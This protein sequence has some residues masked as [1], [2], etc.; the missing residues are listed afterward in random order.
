MK[1]FAR[2]VNLA[3][4]LLLLA[5]TAPGQTVTGTLDGHIT[6]QAGAVVPQVKITAKNVQ[7]G[8]ER[9]TATNETGYFQLPFLPLGNYELTA[10]AA[11]FATVV[12][13]NIQV[14]LNKTTTIS[15]ALKISTV[16]ESVTVR[17]V[18]PL[19]DMTSGQIRRS[20]DDVM[21]GTLPIA[22]RNFLGF[23]GLFPG[24][25]TNPTSGQNN[26][27]L[28]SGSSV[29]FNGTGTRGT[30]F[31]TDG[32]SND[33][34]SENQNRQAVNISTIKEMQLLTDNFAPEFG[35][36][37]GAVVL[38]QTKSGDNTMH[39]EAYW[40]LQ[41]SALN[42]RGY[43]AN[44]A[45][46]RFD[47]AK[48]Q[49]VPNVAKGT[50][51]SHRAGGTLGGAI[52][53]DRLFYFGSMERFWEPGTL[54]ST[55]YL[56][57]PEWRT[58]R[59]DPSVPDA[60]ARRAWVQSLI[61][62]FPANLAPNNAPVSPYAYTA[63]MPRS[64]HTKDYSGRADW[65]LNDNNLVYARYQFSNFFFGRTQEIVKGENIKQDHRFQSVGVTHTHVFSPTTTGEF[66][67]GFGRRRITAGFIDSSDNPPI[68]RWT[69]TGFS[70]IIGNA[71]SYPMQRYQNDYQYVYNLAS[72]V[73]S[74]HTLK[75]GA[76]IRRIQLNDRAENYNRGFWTFASG[77]GFDGMQNFLRGVV[78]SFTQGY[79]PAYVGLRTTEVNLYAQDEFRAAR[80]LTFTLGLRYER[81][82]APGEVNK[83]YD[84]GYG[85]D[86][87]LEPRFG[88]AYSPQSDNGFLK[89]LTGGP[90]NTSIRGGFGLF[91]G[92]IYQSIFSQIGA[93][94]RFNPPNAATL[95]FTNPEMS[96][97]D[98]TGGFVFKPGP[99]TAQV[100]L[101]NVDPNL[102][103]PYTEQWN[104]TIERQLKWNAALAGVLHRQPRHR[105]D[106]LQLAQPAAVPDHLHAAHRV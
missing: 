44:A 73:G 59:V 83:L 82:G 74:K 23:V 90:G 68:V 96:V 49:L 100:S 65:R 76:D 86:A 51:Q 91:H 18:A 64:S 79:G 93:S 101:A 78:T 105:A 58:P 60:A 61:D 102:H 89:L 25:Q 104:F 75:F 77:A 17:D 84:P 12:A 53:K 14:T 47:A 16:Q 36:G 71:S 27:T 2:T 43:F 8:G 38:V 66:R 3:S 46:M 70:P 85:T 26:Y 103:M 99:P 20:V 32:V 35:R 10:Q 29:S 80:G 39:G 48:N 55:S 41:N 24:F 98:P 67:F 13:Q 87:Y 56:L 97:V 9:A 19:I 1:T 28:S 15:L 88:F 62:R 7:T 21:A 11:G 30:T 4:L 52:I 81:V 5:L 92:R 37:F 6:D 33:D 106:L 57:P 40:Y 63:P 34:G 94:T 42:A 50:A 54:V 72:Q 45:G 69:F 22:G 95:G 31:M